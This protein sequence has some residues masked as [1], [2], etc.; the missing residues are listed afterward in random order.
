M[1]TNKDEIPDT[2]QATMINIAGL[3]SIS[4]SGGLSK[5]PQA[6]ANNTS[7]VPSEVECVDTLPR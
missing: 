4:A 1:T 6:N 2:V 3:D 5:Q 7:I